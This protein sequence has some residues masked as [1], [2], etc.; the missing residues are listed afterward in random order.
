MPKSPP[1]TEGADGH[2]DS[3][4][5]TGSA[6]SATD[7]PQHLLE[8]PITP[9]ALGTP[10]ASSVPQSPPDEPLTPT[11][12][13][14]C[15]HGDRPAR[16]RPP[17]PPVVGVVCSAGGLKALEE[18]FAAVPTDSELAWIVMPHLALDQP[19]LLVELLAKHALVPVRS[20][21]AN[22]APQANMVYVAR[23]AQ[24]VTLRGGRMR[25]EPLKQAAQAE[26]ALDGLLTSLAEDLGPAALGVILSGTGDAGVQ[27]LRAIV[28]AGGL[29]VVQLPATAQ[30]SAMPQAGIDAGVA[31]L[32][33][34]PAEIP[35][36]LAEHVRPG[37][38][39]LML[40]DF[41]ED[42]AVQGA[43]RSILALLRVRTRYDFRDYRPS[44][45]SRRIRRRMDALNIQDTAVYLDKLR[46]E[47]A[48]LE[49]LYQE[50]I[51]R[52]DD[53]RHRLL[54]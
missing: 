40:K 42:T 5:S 54:S 29:G 8:A 24:G 39:R 11:P 1:D 16:E 26:A 47:P 19:S 25:I 43:L 46:Q 38:D 15:Q 36:A 18:L 28:N 12:A 49:R 9:H 34:P 20:V 10:D 33:L 32:A 45:V 30:F 52:A 22:T 37:G 31:D 35:A 3:S 4:A 21:E 48:E 7:T 44:M 14:E 2:A 27:G 50:L 51:P 53:R 17:G 23:P 13:T 6:T 41:S